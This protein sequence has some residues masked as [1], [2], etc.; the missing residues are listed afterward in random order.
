MLRSFA[1]WH[2]T[3]ISAS[4]IAI[5]SPDQPTSR[6]RRYS[7]APSMSSCSTSKLVRIATPS[8]SSIITT[9]TSDAISTTIHSTVSAP[10]ACGVCSESGPQPVVS[11]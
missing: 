3:I 10:S 1:T 6:T 8:V 9:G 7:T 2:V 11:M 5:V 4:A